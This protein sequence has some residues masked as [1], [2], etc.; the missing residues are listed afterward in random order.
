LETGEPSGI[1]AGP[2][3]PAWRKNMTEPTLSEIMAAIEASRQ[4]VAQ[5]RTT[6]E[7]R[8][9]A[10]QAEMSALA[11]EFAALHADISGEREADVGDLHM[12]L[13]K[14]I[15]ELTHADRALAKRVAALEN[16]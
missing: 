2:G 11:S 10:L 7:F 12:Q 5:F 14:A 15:R 1:V 9:E 16:R 13:A 6:M 4:D 8:L 3:Y